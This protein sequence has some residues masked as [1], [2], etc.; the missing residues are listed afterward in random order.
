MPY[1][2]THPMPP[3]YPQQTYPPIKTSPMLFEKK[4]SPTCCQTS[5]LARTLYYIRTRREAF[6][7]EQMKENWRIY[8]QKRLSQHQ[9]GYLFE[10][11]EGRRMI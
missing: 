11:K 3:P 6:C 2:D 7:T 5:H 10:E 1:Q 8:A 9:P 4:Q